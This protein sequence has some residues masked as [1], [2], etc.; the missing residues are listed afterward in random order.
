[1]KQTIPNI[2]QAYNVDKKFASTVSNT[3]VVE[4]TNAV[5]N[6]SHSFYNEIQLELVQGKTAVYKLIQQKMIE[7]GWDGLKFNKELP[8]YQNEIN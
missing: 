3:G 5:R 7:F 8:R 1:M 4:F 2:R 6:I